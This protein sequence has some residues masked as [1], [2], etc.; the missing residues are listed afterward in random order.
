MRNDLAVAFPR[1]AIVGRLHGNV[2]ALLRTFGGGKAAR[3]FFLDEI[4][5]P[6]DSG[7]ASPFLKSLFPEVKLAATFERSLNTALGR[8]LDH[9]VT[10]IA[11]AAHAH[12]ERNYSVTGTIPSHTSA[13][14]EGIIR[15]YTAGSGHAS[16]D[17]GTE[18]A[19]I[20]PGVTTPGAQ[21]TVAESDDVYFVTHAGAEN[22]LEVK[23]AKPNYDQGK[24]MK[25]RILRIHAV[26]AAAKPPV[27]V[28]ALVGMP[29]NPNGRYGAYQ[30]PTTKYF[31]DARHDY[32]VG[33]EFWNY[34]GDSAETYDELMDCFLEVASARRR[35][36]LSLLE[37]VAP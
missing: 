31:L 26:R 30:W 32:L 5:S 15:S 13:Q 28:R 14:I 35:D 7:D 9:M 10:D 3:K 25:R 4:A 36:M 17:T 19:Q 27:A 34:V 6:G 11:R 1:A 23:T 37:G 18:L 24:N 16:P 33:P 20:L 29:Y 2:D 22:H 8:G 12:A 21:E